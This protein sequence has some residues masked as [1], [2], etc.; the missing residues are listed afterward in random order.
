MKFWIKLKKSLKLKVKNFQRLFY[1]QEDLAKKSKK[2]LHS[3]IKRKDKDTIEVIM[4]YGIGDALFCVA[5]LNAL[6]TTTPPPANK[7]YCSQAARS[8][9]ENIF[10]H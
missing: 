5:Y 2:L 9:F 8:D 4:G 6:K 1:R 3:L 10:V 7:N